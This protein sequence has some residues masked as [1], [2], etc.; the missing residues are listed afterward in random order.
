MTREHAA[1]QLL[2][3]GALGLKEFEQIT[4]WKYNTC[5]A[6]LGRLRA[7]RKI[8]LVQRSSIR[9]SIYEAI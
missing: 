6:A 8:R 1:V 5:R 9:G 4:G 2:A 3:H 7:K